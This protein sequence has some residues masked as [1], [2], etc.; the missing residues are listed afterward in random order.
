MD[1]QDLIQVNPLGSPLHNIQSRHELD[2][3][4]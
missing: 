1:V 3:K 4:W 2:H